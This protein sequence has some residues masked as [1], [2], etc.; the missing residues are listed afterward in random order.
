MNAGYPV[1]TGSVDALK[2]PV[3]TFLFVASDRPSQGYFV[4][5]IAPMHISCEPMQENADK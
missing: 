4:L 5:R 1:G 3:V 2:I